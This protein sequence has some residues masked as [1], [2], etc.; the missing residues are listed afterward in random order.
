MAGCGA[1]ALA[2]LGVG[3][4]CA[5]VAVSRRRRRRLQGGGGRACVAG[6]EKG[7]VGGGRLREALVAGACAGP[8]LATKLACLAVQ[9]CEAVCTSGFGWPWR[10]QLCGENVDVC[11]QAERVGVCGCGWGGGQRRRCAWA[12]L[13]V[14]SAGGPRGEVALSG[15][16]GAQVAESRP[17]CGF[18]VSGVGVQPWAR[19]RLVG[20]WG[21]A[22]DVD[23]VV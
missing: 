5:G 1:L 19:G 6:A 3:K 18:G 20:W 11:E 2:G 17:P 21:S 13:S 22:M 8:N 23:G 15:T 4:A 14:N 10:Q 7:G 16:D 12:A 9:S